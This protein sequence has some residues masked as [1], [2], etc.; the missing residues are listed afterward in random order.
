MKYWHKKS[1]T[2]NA[3]VSYAKVFNFTYG[4]VSF[5]A[6]LIAAASG[7]FLAIPFDIKNPLD[8]LSYMLLTNPG[9]VLFRNIHYWSAQLFLIFSV[10]HIYDHLKKSTE[11]D[12]NKGVWLRLTFSLAV[13]FFVMLSGFIIKADAD[14]VQ[15]KRIVTSLIDFIPFIGKELSVSLFGPD[16]NYQILYVHHIATATI[17]LFIII[18][19]HAK[20]IWPRL[21][22]VLYLLPILIFTGYLFPPGLHD[23]LN[24]IIKGPWYFLGLQEILHWLSH[25]SIIIFLSIFYFLVTAFLPKY[26]I[27][28]SLITKKFIL[29]SFIIYSV[30][31]IIGY[32]FRGEDWKFVLPWNNPAVTGFQFE[33]FNNIQSASEKELELKSIPVVLG[34]R[35]GCLFCHSNT[36]GFSP[37]HNPE[38]IGCVSCHSGNPFTLNK[39]YAHQ[40]MFLIPG[41]LDAAK[42]TCGTANCHGEIVDRV[43]KTIMTTLSGIVSVDRYTFG[44]TKDL[45]K[46]HFISEIGHSPADT[47]LRNLCA[48]CHLGGTKTELGPINQ[49]SRGGGCNACHLNYSDSA[50]VSLSAYKKNPLTLTNSSNPFVHPSL[51][52][53]ITNDHCFGCHSRSGRIS[54]NYEGWHDTLLQPGEVKD[55][56]IYRI[57]DDGRVFVKA[58]EDIHHA[59]GMECIDCH[60]SHEV[61]GDGKYYMHEEDQAKVS[62]TDCHFYG[63]PQTKTISEVDQESQ[64]IIYLRNFE[65][66]DRKFLVVKKSGYPLINTYLNDK[67]KPELLTKNKNEILPLIPPALICAAGKGH[68][69]LSCSSCHTS[70]S[71]Q[72]VG[73]HTKYEPD[74][75]SYDL[76]SRKE[77]QGKWVETPSDYLA[78]PPTL[79]IRIIKSNNGK[80]ME[81]VDTFI[82][83][84]VLTI[85]KKNINPNSPV[86]KNIIFRRLFAPTFSHTITKQGRTCVSCHNNPVA[87]G[88]GRGKLEYVKHGS[89]GK[90]NFAP[91]YPLSHY[92]GLPQD[93]WIGFLQTRKSY[94]ATRTNVRPFSVEEQKNILTVGACLTC[95]QPESKPMMLYLN[96]GEM[97]AVSSKC[98]LPK[99]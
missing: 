95:H 68:G 59:K 55:S 38:A 42:K 1:K 88:Y 57:L 48:S 44:E 37:A 71:P 86:N 61:M 46:I 40:G 51:S 31:I 89:F 4:Q 22:L 17:F 13:I 50:L 66:K 39:T 12:V 28:W 54:T 80:Q 27:K 29:V 21:R 58:Q 33:P 63:N 84:M 8:S 97:P 81:T 78:E 24:P 83:G 15:A 94:F 7:V 67:G 64:R 2:E 16:N 49:L 43:D 26:S 92:D 20:S 47:H 23:G 45:N 85:Q 32:Y 6:F 30:L 82:P 76:L 60:T 96:S 70:W 34:R 98:V 11:K 99:W 91:Q 75:N 79:G 10:L 65:Q 93:A 72:C 56:S 25:P 73:C 5:A 41:N 36:K 3:N 74:E 69:K 90:W 19:E 62:C 18:I 53:K 35:E 14:S 77:V 87:L 9:G 52:I